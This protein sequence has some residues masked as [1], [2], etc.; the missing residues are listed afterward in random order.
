MPDFSGVLACKRPLLFCTHHIDHL[1][2]DG[3]C[4]S[5]SQIAVVALLE[6]YA[7][8]VCCLHLEFV[9][10]FST[11]LSCYTFDFVSPFVV[12]GLAIILYANTAVILQGIFG[13]FYF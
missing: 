3:A 11:L 1:T 4:F 7:N 10:S 6:V 2:A 9:E 8:F 12:F 5:G 13:V